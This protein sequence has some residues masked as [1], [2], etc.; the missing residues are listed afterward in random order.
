MPWSSALPEGAFAAVVT[1][2]EVAHGKPHPEPYRAAARLLGVAPEDCVAIEDSP[3]GVR[4]AVAAG[5]PTLAVPH[6]VPVPETAGAVHVDGLARDD[7][8][9]ASPSWPPRCSLVGGLGRA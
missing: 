3:T 9:R 2:D 6:V 7:A 5:V 4:S 8:G 1:G